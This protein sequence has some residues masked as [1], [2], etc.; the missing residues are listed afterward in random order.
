MV[1]QNPGSCTLVDLP[2]FRSLWFSVIREHWRTREWR[3]TCSLTLL[4]QNWYS[5]L[6]LIFHWQTQGTCPLLEVGVLASVAPDWTAGSQ[7]WPHSGEG[8]GAGIFGE[9]ST[10]FATT[11]ILNKRR[12]SISLDLFSCSFSPMKC[13][14][15]WLPCFCLVLGGKKER[16]NHFIFSFHAS[17]SYI[18]S[19]HWF[20]ISELD[21]S[22]N[23]ISSGLLTWREIQLSHGAYMYIEIAAKLMEKWHLQSEFLYSNLHLSS[24]ILG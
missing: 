16:K 14:Q 2:S 23:S 10:V 19:E 5:F 3:H 1:A 8:A 21:W 12:I 7:Q 17:N 9:P 15:G 22:N 18:P 13:L 4:A 6:L 11:V 20:R 24:F